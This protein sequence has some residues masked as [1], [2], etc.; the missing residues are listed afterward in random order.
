M[1]L[2]A[3]DTLF[4]LRGEA[5]LTGDALVPIEQIGLG[6][7]RTVRGYRQDLLLTDNGFLASAEVRL[8]VY[9]N[10][11]HNSLV[12]LIPFIDVGTG[13]NVGSSISTPDPN[14]IVGTGLGLQWQQG[15]RFT[16]RF[17]WGIPLTDI[18]LSEGTL[19]EDGIYFS[20]R[21]RAF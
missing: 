15:D 6:G 21:Y 2:L 14:T 20:I 8:P 7:R 16:A 1:N 17:D 5:Q 12:Q 4:I 3:P 10:Q 11:R 9:R 13:W 19:Q 18:D